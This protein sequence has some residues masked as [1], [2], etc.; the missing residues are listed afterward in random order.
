MWE[1]SAGGRHGLHY[2]AR[3]GRNHSGTGHRGHQS[4]HRRRCG[5]RVTRMRPAAGH[6][7]RKHAC[8]RENRQG[9]RERTEPGRGASFVTRFGTFLPAHKMSYQT[10][11][12]SVLGDRHDR[13][14]NK[15]PAKRQHL[16]PKLHAPFLKSRHKTESRFSP[17]PK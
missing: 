7:G 14:P 6:Q 8:H 5:R 17:Y 13:S 4:Q 2:P 10:W 1:I 9:I 16:H 12:H 15:Q 11:R 3:K